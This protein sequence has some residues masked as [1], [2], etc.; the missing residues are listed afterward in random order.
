MAGFSFSRIE[1]IGKR[2]D[3]FTKSIEQSQK[4]IKD[5]PQSRLK[6]ANESFKTANEKLIEAKMWFTRGSL[7]LAG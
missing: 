3:N 5:I 6:D 1:E 7:L 4:I 2:S